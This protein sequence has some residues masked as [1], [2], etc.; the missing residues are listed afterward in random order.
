MELLTVILSS[1][2]ISSIVT[3]ILGYIFENK[4]YIRDRKMS[5]Y[6]DFLEQL[7]KLFPAEEI[8]GD[9]EK[10]KLI[11]KMKI[12]ASNLEKYI[13]KMKLIS[14][15]KKIHAYADELFESSEKLIEGL[16]ADM[17]DD[18][19]EPI[20]EESENLRDELIGNMNKD[21]NRF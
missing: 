7:D 16:S 15:D 12:E 11:K 4:K 13:W 5:L 2:V 20:I 6:S 3:I 19:L 14:R 9:A 18:K 8:F 21:I 10:D 1:A 17:D